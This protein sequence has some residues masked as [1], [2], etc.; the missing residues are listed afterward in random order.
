MAHV[1]RG[2]A[3]GAS[4]LQSRTARSTRLAVGHTHARTHAHTHTHI[5]THTYTHTHA[6]HSPLHPP[7]HTHTHTRALCQVRDCITDCGADP[8][9]AGFTW[10]HTD[11]FGPGIAVTADCTGKKGQ[12]CCYMQS[13]AEISG[14]GSANEFDC[15]RSKGLP[16]P[17]PPPGS[18]PP[19]CVLTTAR[20]TPLCCEQQSR[21]NRPHVSHI[22]FAAE[23]YCRAHLR[24]Y[25]CVCV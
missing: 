22:M 17:G 15:W 19:V 14:W 6:R 10:K 3:P 25:V 24:C 2:S 23:F 20:N 4:Q 8:A 16:P 1:A 13:A 18:P 9:C 11:A 21:V 12:P 7:T 5:H